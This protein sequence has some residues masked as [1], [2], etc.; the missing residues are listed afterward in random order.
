MAGHVISELTSNVAERII[1]GVDV[2]AEWRRAR[3]EEDRFHSV[4]YIH[5]HKMRCTLPHLQLGT[6]PSHACLTFKNQSLA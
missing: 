6:I 5:M 4:Q 1:A 2:G 3:R